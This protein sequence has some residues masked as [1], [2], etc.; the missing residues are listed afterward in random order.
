MS[1]ARYCCCGDTCTNPTGTHTI[2]ST[3]AAIA[4][5]T[6]STQGTDT[7]VQTFDYLQDLTLNGSGSNILSTS[8]ARIRTHRTLDWTVPDGS[9]GTIVLGR[10]DRKLDA[11][12]TISG[13]FDCTAGFS[14]TCG[15]CGVGEDPTSI[16]TYGPRLRTPHIAGSTQILA[17]T[18]NSYTN[19][20][21]SPTT[22]PSAVGFVVTNSDSVN[23]GT[24]GSYLYTYD[25]STVGQQIFTA[26]QPPHWEPLRVWRSGKTGGNPTNVCL[27][28]WTIWDYIVTSGPGSGV[29][30][31]PLC[32]GDKTALE[33]DGYT[34]STYTRTASIT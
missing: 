1:G 24:T 28:Q 17:V 33:A 13:D 16:Y 6:D 4:S 31:Q 11:T 14:H 30:N 34:F 10:F 9:G 15:D 27:P 3:F 29:T 2:A 22:A 19:T 21:T 23:P 32:P 7:R 12:L 26:T 25:G 5:K 20:A 8:T 18:V